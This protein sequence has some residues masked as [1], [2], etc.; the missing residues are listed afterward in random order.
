[1]ELTD[2]DMAIRSF[3]AGLIL[4]PDNRDEVLASIGT[5]YMKKGNTDKAQLFF[6]LSLEAN[7]NNAGAKSSMAA[8]TPPATPTVVPGAADTPSPRSGQT[9]QQASPQRP[10]PPPVKPP[11]K[12]VGAIPG[13]YALEGTNPNG[14]RYTGMVE[15]T[16]SG[17]RYFVTWKIADQTFTGAGVLLGQILTVNRKGPGAVNG[18]VVYGRGANG[19][20]NG[21]W[22]SGKGKET[23]KPAD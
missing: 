11:V 6:K 7:P 21:T 23:L 22:G 10:V 13:N 15:I 4:M 14:G 20:L 18:G 12:P 9:E 16:Q 3:E 19:V 1:M 5:C 2:L 8:L 17:G